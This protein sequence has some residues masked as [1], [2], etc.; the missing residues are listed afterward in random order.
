MKFNN[1]W[2]DVSDQP[3]TE[4]NFR[5]TGGD[6]VTNGRLEVCVGE[7]WGAVCTTDFN[8]ALASQA[9][10]SMGQQGTGEGDYSC[11]MQDNNTSLVQSCRC[12]IPY[13]YY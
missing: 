9:C 11:Y 3:C 2:I 5:T 4:G 6:G 1:A 12:V 8:D 10:T 7:L 13:N